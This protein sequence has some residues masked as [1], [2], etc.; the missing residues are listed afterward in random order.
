MAYPV[1]SL[2]RPACLSGQSNGRLSASIMR[3][4][5][6]Q[7]GGVGVLLAEPAA[8][9]WRALC[10]AA[11]GA[12]HTLKISHSTNAYRPYA[13]QERIFRDRYTTTY[14]P[15]RPYRYWNGKRWYQRPG[16][17]VAAVPGT[18]NHGWGLAVDTGEERDWDL[19]AE[20]ID[21]GTLAWLLANEQ[22]FGF[23]HEVQSEPWH[24][25]Y[26]AGDSIPAAVLAYERGASPA[27]P[28][29]QP[30]EED[31]MTGDEL[32]WLMENDPR[33]DAAVK[34]KIREAQTPL[35]GIPLGADE[36]ADV[37]VY[38]L[39]AVGRLERAVADLTSKLS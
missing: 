31:D 33:L 15:G 10:A 13:D 35:S 26:F 21:D 25:R 38:I 17:A 20:P 29:P 7:A 2:S 6:G 30:S 8:R 36:I 22:T 4:V 12:G 19:A 27:P 16:T 9:A 5:P 23:S 11:A 32:I 24:I 37:P 39:E 18:S 14:L 3:E 28:P 34:K 1:R